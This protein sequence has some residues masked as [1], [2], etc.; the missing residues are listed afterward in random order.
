ME[1]GQPEFRGD[2]NIMLT[3]LI[4]SLEVKKKKWETINYHPPFTII[5][6]KKI[7]HVG[8]NICLTL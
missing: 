4:L 3:S 2:G 7:A 5:E 8:S 1:K 6:R